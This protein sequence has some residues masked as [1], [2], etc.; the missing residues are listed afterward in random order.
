MKTAIEIFNEILPAII[1]NQ[2]TQFYMKNKQFFPTI[3]DAKKYASENW[4]TLTKYNEGAAKCACGESFAFISDDTNDQLIVC[5]ACAKSQKS[6]F[7]H[8]KKTN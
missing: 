8:G 6:P 3:E 4:Q 7:H 2:I 1:T 5:E